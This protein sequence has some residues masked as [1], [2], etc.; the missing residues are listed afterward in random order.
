MRAAVPMAELERI[1]SPDFWRDVD[2]F[3]G[4]QIPSMRRVRE[5]AE[6]WLDSLDYDDQVQRRDQ[7]QQARREQLA[8]QMP[9]LGAGPLERARYRAAQRQ[10]AR[11]P[12]RDP[13]KTG[14]L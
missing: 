2:A 1:E 3:S 9:G 12:S 6:Q 14:R 8:A 13:G 4:A 7:D 5:Q 11:R 10:F